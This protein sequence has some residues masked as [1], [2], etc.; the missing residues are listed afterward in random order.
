MIQADLISYL[1][2]RG[3][4]AMPQLAKGVVTPLDNNKPHFGITCWWEAECADCHDKLLYGMARYKGGFQP[5]QIQGRY[6]KEYP[7]IMIEALCGRCMRIAQEEE[8]M[9]RIQDQCG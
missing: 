5:E 2:S 7:D 8:Y 1:S 3:Y 4:P 6:S 9:Q